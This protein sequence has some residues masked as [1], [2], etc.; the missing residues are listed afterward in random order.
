VKS[1]HPRPHWTALVVLAAVVLSCVPLAAEGA[2]KGYPE[3]VRDIRYRSPADGT[4]Q[5]ALFYAP[6]K[7]EAV[8]LLVALHTW[9]GNY[10]QTYNVQCAK[11]CI[12]KGWAFI[13]PDFRG[14]NRNP[15]ATGSEL[16]VADIVGAVKHAMGTARVDASR[17]YLFG[18]SGGGHMS[19]V[20]AGRHPEIW[21]G[22]SS[23]VPITDLKAWYVECKAAGR[24]YAADI[25]ASVGGDPT[26]SK[27]AAEEC[28]RRSPLTYLLNAR[29][30][31]LDI[32]AGIRDGHSGS[33]P[34]SHTLNAFNLLA[35]PK[36]R[37]SPEQIIHF[38]KKAAAPPGVGKP[39]VDRLYGS[40]KVLFRRQSGNTR[41]TIF[42]GGHE[43]VY[44]AALD[45]LSR[46]RK[47]RR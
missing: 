21:A 13:H 17:I 19:L 16:A 9:S 15:K 5:R 20:M 38:V 23:W 37:L 14:P 47:P 4:Y 40:K 46:Q 8:P 30:L 25:A 7:A 35:D 32:N 24:S 18:A 36:Q 34:I 28:R 12:D 11:W 41:V 3:A 6:P 2:V 33:V 10:R 43:A 22:V 31:P 39:P 42:Q 44:G 45:W 27:R 29:G 1:I 26:A